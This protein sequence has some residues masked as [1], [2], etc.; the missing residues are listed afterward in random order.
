[1]LALASSSFVF[2]LFIWVH[3]TARAKQ[4][5]KQKQNTHKI[6][7]QKN[8]WALWLFDGGLTNILIW[9]GGVEHRIAIAFMQQKISAARKFILRTMAASA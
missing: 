2:S 6:E 3:T 9:R 8:M 5:N 4:T 1:M 7:Q